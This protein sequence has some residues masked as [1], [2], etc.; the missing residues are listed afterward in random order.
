MNVV[1]FLYVNSARSFESQIF[2]LV[3]PGPK[4][5]IDAD[6]FTTFAFYN[7]SWE[8]KSL[9]MSFSL[10]MQSGYKFFI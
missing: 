5:V 1:V 10:F 3:S 2:L 7:Y 4:L 9:F 6:A 8:H